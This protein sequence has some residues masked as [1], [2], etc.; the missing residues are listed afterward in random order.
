MSI[1][2]GSAR[3]L[4]S[5]TELGLPRLLLELLLWLLFN[6]FSSIKYC[7]GGNGGGFPVVI[8]M[9]PC[10][11]IWINICELIFGSDNAFVLFFDRFFLPEPLSLLLLLL[12]V[13]DEVGVGGVMLLELLVPFCDDLLNTPPS[14][15][16][17]P[18]GLPCVLGEEI[19][20]LP[21]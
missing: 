11:S 13:F 2:L 18:I 7:R 6:R 21:E 4:L 3:W 10:C 19:I 8:S 5:S 16:T 15:A 1:L 12:L 20:P 9:C 17:C 14:D